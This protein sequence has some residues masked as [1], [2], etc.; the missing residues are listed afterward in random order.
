[1]SSSQIDATPDVGVGGGRRRVCPPASGTTGRGG[2]QNRTA[3]TPL[4]PQRTVQTT[5]FLGRPTSACRESLV[6]RNWWRTEANSPAPGVRVTPPRAP[7]SSYFSHTTPSLS[8]SRALGTIAAGNPRPDPFDPFTRSSLAAAA[9]SHDGYC[10]DAGVAVGPTAAVCLGVTVCVGIATG[11]AV[12][13]T[14]EAPQVASM[15]VN[16]VASAR[17]A[18]RPQR[19]LTSI[20]TVA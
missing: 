11:V 12:V 20:Q 8:P 4:A 7:L 2:T 9:A 16:A 14:T 13:V 18:V 1:M 3:R 5:M 6:I 10:F 15:S 17:V 19:C